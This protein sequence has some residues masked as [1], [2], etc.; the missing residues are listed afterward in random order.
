MVRRPST[1]QPLVVAASL[2]AVEGMVLLLLAVVE[3]ATLSRDRMTMGATTA[4]FFGALGVLLV[5]AGAALA[6]RSG[7][8]RGPVLISQL[9]VLGLAWSFR[10]VVLVALTLAVAALVALAGVL[11][12]DSIAALED[13]EV[14]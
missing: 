10:D 9:L 2:A 1:P 12:P 7:W 6:R 14:S 5:L 11:H 4:V 3:L 13:R 8:A